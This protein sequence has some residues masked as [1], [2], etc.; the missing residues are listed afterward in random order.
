MVDN[1]NE[2]KTKVEEIQEYD[3]IY[4]VL[5]IGESGVGKTAMIQRYKNPELALHDFL[6]TIGI[7]FRLVDLKIDGLRVRVQLWDTVGQE[8]YRTMTTNFF[9]GANGVLLLF[10]VT[11][12]E[13]FVLVANWV[14][15]LKSKD[16]DKE[17]VFMIGNKIDLDDKRKISYKEGKR[18]ACSYGFKYFETSAKT[19]ENIDDVIQHLI[20]NIKDA[21]NPM[22]DGVESKDNRNDRSRKYRGES[23]IKLGGDAQMSKKR[24]FFRRFCKLL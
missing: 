2:N 8:R 4:K 20:H 15:S 13:S 21:N 1:T 6:P 11:N 18:F 19:G 10:D 5:L 12:R 3:I 22:E 9:R 17:E 14:T 7:D 23:V 24:K 16:I